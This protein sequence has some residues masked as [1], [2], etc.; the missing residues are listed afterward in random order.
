MH[1]ARTDQGME[2]RYLLA[3]TRTSLY[4]LCFYRFTL[5]SVAAVHSEM[6]DTATYLTSGLHIHVVI[7]WDLCWCGSRQGLIVPP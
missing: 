6:A 3:L 2:A 5:T 7:C 4:S 1:V